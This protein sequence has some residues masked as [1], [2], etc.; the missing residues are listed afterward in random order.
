MEV[1]SGGRERR[2]PERFAHRRTVATSPRRRRAW[3]P[4]ECRRKCGETSASTP[5]S[6]AARRTRPQA[7]HTTAD[8]IEQRHVKIRGEDRYWYRTVSKQGNT[9]DF[10]L[11]AKRDRSEARRFFTRA[12]KTN[13]NNR[14]P[15]VVNNDKSCATATTPRDLVVSVRNVRPVTYGLCSSHQSV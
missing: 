14:L 5:A 12:V 10:L 6:R 8:E 1:A 9:V 3:V 7:F 2:V 4:C 13:K 11:T 15:K